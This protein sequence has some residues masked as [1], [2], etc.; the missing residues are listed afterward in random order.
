MIYNRHEII[1]EILIREANFV[2]I[3]IS[4]SVQG[5]MRSTFPSAS[6]DQSSR[7][8][9]HS[10]H[11]R[12]SGMDWLKRGLTPCCPEFDW[13]RWAC[14]RTWLEAGFIWTLQT[15]LA[16]CEL[17]VPLRTLERCF[18][19]C[20]A[21]PWHMRGW[22]GLPSLPARCSPGSLNAVQRCHPLCFLK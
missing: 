13:M 9:R 5:E 11:T 6:G 3:I 1:N 8:S 22:Q 17:P 15:S 2:K 19:S 7:D 18:Y 20:W 16:G 10:W 12:R 4:K 21:E 14:L